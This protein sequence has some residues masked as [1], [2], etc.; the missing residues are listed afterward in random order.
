M[1]RLLL[2]GSL[3]ALLAIGGLAQPQ[4]ELSGNWKMDASRSQF[5]GP[6]GAPANVLISFVQEGRLLRETLTVINDS[7][8]TIQSITY[9]LDGAERANGSG[10]ELIKSK[11]IRAGDALVLQ[12]QDEGG[13]YSR[14]LS[15]SADHRTLTINVSDSAPD[16]EPAD[17]IVLVRQ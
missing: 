14:R 5:F 1:K 8:R 10:A 17:V 2:V 6:R 7:G 4:T 16:G 13:T 12:W 9:D 11:I 15:F 3:I